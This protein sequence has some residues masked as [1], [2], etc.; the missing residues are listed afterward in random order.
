MIYINQKKLIKRN[1]ILKD[2][3]TSVINRKSDI[4][5]N[6]KSSLF[7]GE[8]KG[9]EDSNPFENII[10]KNKANDNH[11]NNDVIEIIQENINMELDNKKQEDFIDNSLKDEKEQK[12]ENYEALNQV[13]QGEDI[14]V[15]NS[16]DRNKSNKG[17]LVNLDFLREIS[18]I[19]FKYK[20][21][22]IFKCIYLIFICNKYLIKFIRNIF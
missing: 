7:R 11:N 14:L 19:N 16:K 12:E 4:I 13:N 8:V 5:T 15:K 3:R 22:N 1:T 2:N 10:S 9:R 17:K 21:I 18:K 6:L 20:Q